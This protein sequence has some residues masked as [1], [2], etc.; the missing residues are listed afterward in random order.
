MKKYI[1]ITIGAFIL[2]GLFVFAESASEKA[3][4]LKKKRTEVALQLYNRRLKLIEEDPKLKEIHEKIL[5]LHKEL[6]L[7]L[8][9]DREIIEL[10]TQIRDIDSDLERLADQIRKDKEKE[11]EGKDK[12]KDAAK[13]KKE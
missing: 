10:T 7:K 2:C 8:E 6:A 3:D 5:T 1:L 4:G 12:E 11:D 9:N 13:E